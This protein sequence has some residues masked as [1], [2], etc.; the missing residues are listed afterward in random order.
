MKTIRLDKPPWF[1]LQA[2]SDFYAGFV[3]GS[4]MAGPWTASHILFRGAA[5]ADGLPLAEARVLHG[6]ADAS[7][8]D[9]PSPAAFHRMAEKWRPFRMWVSILLAR[10]WPALKAGANPR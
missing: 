9:V 3:P 4:G 2:A 10:H 7:G 5:L 1:A 8:I 6:L